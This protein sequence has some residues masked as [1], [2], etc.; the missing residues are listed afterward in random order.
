[1]DHKTVQ[2]VITNSLRL[3]SRFRSSC[4]VSEEQR[5]DGLPFQLW[6]TGGMLRLEHPTFKLG[7]R[8]DQLRGWIT[9]QLSNLP[10]YPYTV[11]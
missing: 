1:M 3:L 7:R 5:P 9:P 4:R 2:H 11:E 10:S 8:A 6:V